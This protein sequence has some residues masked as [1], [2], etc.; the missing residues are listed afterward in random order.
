MQSPVVL[1]SL[2]THRTYST[3]LSISDAVTEVQSGY[4]I[5][6]W[7]AN[8]RKGQSIILLPSASIVCVVG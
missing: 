8:G 4:Y 7:Q 5:C 6:V 1:E 3:A 2:K